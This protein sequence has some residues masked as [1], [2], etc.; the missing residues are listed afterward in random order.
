VVGA[1]KAEYLPC[2][3]SCGYFRNRATSRKTVS[4]GFAFCLAADTGIG[5]TLFG[6]A[7]RDAMR[8]RLSLRCE[9][10]NNPM[11]SSS[12]AARQAPYNPFVA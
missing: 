3:L 6:L 10:G 11:S 7:L 2:T 8:G 4:D 9:K 12:G 5:K 1:V